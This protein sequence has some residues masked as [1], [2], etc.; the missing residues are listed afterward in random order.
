M[1]YFVPILV[2]CLIP[3]VA[4]TSYSSTSSSGVL[5]PSSR[6]HIESFK[7]MDVLKKANELQN[8]GKEVFHFEIGQPSTPAPR[9]VLKAAS[10]AIESDT[11]SL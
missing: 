3:E 8:A 9:G 7:V 1:V 2:L 6:S 5:N 4:S 10:T 11:V